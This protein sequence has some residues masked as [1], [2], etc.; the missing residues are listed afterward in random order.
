MNDYGRWKN[1]AQR[2][3]ILEQDCDRFAARLEVVQS[4]EEGRHGRWLLRGPWTWA[5]VVTLANGI[6]VGGDIDTVVFVGGSDRADRPRGRVYWMATRSYGYA[7]EKARAG[8]TAPDEWDEACALGD[9]LWHRRADQ[10]TR[11]QARALWDLLKRGNVHPHEFA[12]AIYDETGDAELC[13]MGDVTPR[14]IFMATAILRRLAALFDAE[15]FRAQAHGW[16]RWRLGRALQLC[17]F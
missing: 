5:E 4:A 13:N 10:L 15:D 14:R 16:F 1:S 9:I 12:S 11:E 17:G 3:R 7:R 2:G 8:D 6:Y